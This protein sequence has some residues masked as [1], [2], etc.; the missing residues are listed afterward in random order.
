MFEAD[1]NEKYGLQVANRSTAAT[2]TIIRSVLD[3]MMRHR[4]L[5]QDKK[6][7][8]L[9]N[10]IKELVREIE[11]II[12]TNMLNHGNELSDLVRK[13]MQAQFTQQMVMAKASSQPPSRQGRPAAPMPAP[14]Q[15]NGKRSKFLLRLI[16]GRFSHLFSDPKSPVF[17]REVV[18][19]FNDYLD[20][21]LG[22]VLYNELNVEAQ[23][24][25]SQFHT[26]DDGEIWKRIA[27]N[28]RH[29]RFAYNIL[30]RI[31]LKFEDFEWARRNFI[32]ILTNVT[33]RTSGFVF[34]DK[35]FQVLFSALFS[36]IF[37]ALWDDEESMKLDFMF[38]EGTSDRIDGIRDAFKVYKE[39]E[40]QR[41]K[42]RA[43]G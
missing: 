24:L 31:L 14:Q 8:E 21:L 1:D 35:H 19:A 3:L 17:P 20:K 5:T 28:D 6:T 33:E 4:L 2:K 40:N 10:D 16:A 29:K 37:R 36:D 41:A 39:L 26:D 18:G 7:P 30:I 42:A 32:N 27:T 15:E 38:G 12:R 22:E 9:D 43:A 13:D 23:E 11:V 34:E 25:L